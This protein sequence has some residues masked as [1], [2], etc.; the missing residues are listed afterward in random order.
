MVGL[1]SGGLALS[2]DRSADSVADEF[3]DG[4][5]AVGECEDFDQRS[6]K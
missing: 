5:L 1:G 3:L 2:E 4:R 6:F